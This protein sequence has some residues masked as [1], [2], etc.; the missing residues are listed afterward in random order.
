MLYLIII[1]YPHRKNYINMQ[2][3]REICDIIANDLKGT[4]VLYFYF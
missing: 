4:A 2:K 1:I 3:K